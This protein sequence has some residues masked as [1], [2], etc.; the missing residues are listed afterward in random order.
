LKRDLGSISLE[1]ADLPDL[2]DLTAE[3]PPLEPTILGLFRGPALGEAPKS[4]PRAIVLYR[5]NLDVVRITDAGRESNQSPTWAPNGRA[6]AYESSRG[7]IWISTADGRIEKQ[8]YA[9]PA[10]TPAW[11]CARRAEAAP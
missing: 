10:A 7:G 3:H 9:G 8:V 5:K 2:G 11:S 6:I 1:I 4:E